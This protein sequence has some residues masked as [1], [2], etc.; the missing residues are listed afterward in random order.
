MCTICDISY[1]FVKSEKLNL[2]SVYREP[3]VL[4]YQIIEVNYLYTKT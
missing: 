3:F 4:T 1:F 2:A